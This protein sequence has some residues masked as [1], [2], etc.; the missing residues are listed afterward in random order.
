MHLSN[1][2]GLGRSLEKALQCRSRHGILLFINFAFTTHNQEALP[3]EV[4]PSTN[5]SCGG[6][7]LSP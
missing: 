7:H 1:R 4:P 3:R 6:G 5:A 2:R